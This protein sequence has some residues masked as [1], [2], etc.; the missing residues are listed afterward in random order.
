MTPDLNKWYI[1]YV[2]YTKFRI[3]NIYIIFMSDFTDLIQA[4]KDSF[5]VEIRKKEL[6]S[7]LKIKRLKI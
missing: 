4:K 7:K 5:R 2:K 1:Y 6:G 3:F